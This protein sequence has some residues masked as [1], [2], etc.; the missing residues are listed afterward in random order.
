MNADKLKRR[1]SLLVGSLCNDLSMP[2]ANS[3]TEYVV[4][5]NR[6]E[7]FALGSF[8][9]SLEVSL[10]D[11]DYDEVLRVLLVVNVFQK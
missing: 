7:G 9:F 8:P 3:R 5:C 6:R 2:R 4:V 10:G 11:K 1:P